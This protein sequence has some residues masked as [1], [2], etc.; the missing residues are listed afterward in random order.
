MQFFEDS[1]KIVQDILSNPFLPATT[2]QKIQEMLK[3]LKGY[4]EEMNSGSLKYYTNLFLDADR[5]Y[6]DTLVNYLESV[7]NYITGVFGNKTNELANYLKNLKPILDKYKTF[8]QNS[9][10]EWVKLFK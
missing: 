8:R 7:S 4:L 2:N 9:F 10:T 6:V 5:L 1:I 3:Q